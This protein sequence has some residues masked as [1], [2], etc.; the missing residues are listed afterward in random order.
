M[1]KALRMLVFVFL[2]GLFTSI[3]LVGVDAW[4]SP[5]IE[6][7]AQ[8]RLRSAVLNAHG[9]NYTTATINDVFEANIVEDIRDGQTFYVNE[10]TGAVAFVFEGNGVWGPIVGVIAFESDLRTIQYIEILEQEETPGL[11]ARI[12][13]RPYLN[14]FKHVTMRAEA[15][16]LTISRSADPD[17]PNDLDAITG[18]TRTSDR[19]QIMLNAAYAAFIEL[20]DVS[21]EEGRD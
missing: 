12:V 4:T 10:T 2:M 8:A 17:D 7:N 20:W 21:F 3:L 1:N 16:F 18:A 5:Y 13:E 6:A 15:P 19:F 9:F 11:G 14:T